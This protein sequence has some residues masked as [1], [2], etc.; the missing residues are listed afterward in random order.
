MTQKK[1]KKKT[2]GACGEEPVFH[3][4][5]FGL[6]SKNNGEPVKGFQ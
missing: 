1:R 3:A 5:D 6:D 4:K 2:A